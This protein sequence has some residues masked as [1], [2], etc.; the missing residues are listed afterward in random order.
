MNLADLLNPVNFTEED[1][2]IIKNMDPIRALFCEYVINGMPKED[3]YRLAKNDLNITE[4]TARK[5]AWVWNKDKDV[6][7]Y[8]AYL[9]NI[10]RELYGSEFNEIFQHMTNIALGNKQ[11]VT[12]RQETDKDGDTKTTIERQDDI[13][14][15]LDA[16]KTILGYAGITVQQG[17][18]SVGTPQICIKDDL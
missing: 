17:T 9:K 2:N 18:S 16:C 10:N 6:Q 5:Q 8:I 13:R 15:Q 1:L 12:V 14:V 7:L 11:M 4:G 3:A